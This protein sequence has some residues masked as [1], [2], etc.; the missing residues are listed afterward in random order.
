[1]L[2]AFILL[3]LGAKPAFGEAGVFSP[4]LIPSSFHTQI[5]LVE[6]GHTQAEAAAGKPKS[7]LVL[8]WLRAAPGLPA[9]A[10]GWPPAM[11][12][13]P[14][15]P[16]ARPPLPVLPMLA[17]IQVAPGVGAALGCLGGVGW[18]GAPSLA[19]C[20]VMPCLGT[21]GHPH[22]GLSPCPPSALHLVPVVPPTYLAGDAVSSHSCPAGR[23]VGTWWLR[24]G[25]A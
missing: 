12:A 2:L 25:G 16:G 4:I 14:T 5:S 24:E 8:Q 15:L 7:V 1:M 21:G 10:W 6:L 23:A 20:G 13:M 18:V 22:F 17:Q 19:L 11:A 9:G 3:F